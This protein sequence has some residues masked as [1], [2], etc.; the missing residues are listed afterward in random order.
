[1]KEIGT[2]IMIIIL[3]LFTIFDPSIKKIKSGKKYLHSLFS[4]SFS[5]DELTDSIKA[6]R[7]MNSS[8]NAFKYHQDESRISTL[9]NK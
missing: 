7:Q 4:E 5:D 1:M 2:K 3:S 9:V 6:F 8:E